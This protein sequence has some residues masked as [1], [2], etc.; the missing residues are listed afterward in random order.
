MPIFC[1][2]I[3]NPSIASSQIVSPAFKYL[4]T[5]FV[6]DYAWSIILPTMP[7]AVFPSS[8]LDWPA[9]SRKDKNSMKSHL[10]PPV[11]AHF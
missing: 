2:D 6:L 10:P 5:S 8:H 3:V 9:K 7:G 11:P 4:Y 1:G